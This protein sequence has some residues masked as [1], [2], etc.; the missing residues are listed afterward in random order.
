MSSL[1]V[2]SQIHLT[3]ESLEGND[4]FFKR[5]QSL[6]N[7]LLKYMKVFLL[8]YDSN[9]HAYCVFNKDSSCVET[10]CDAMFDV[11]NGSQVEQYDL[12][13][14]DDEEATCDV[15]QRMAIRDVRPQDSSEPQASNDTIPPTQYH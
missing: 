11:I 4:I 1:S 15:L 8:S 12:D 7:L 14:V 6:L 9:S 13:V 5:G 10:T 2:T 3:L